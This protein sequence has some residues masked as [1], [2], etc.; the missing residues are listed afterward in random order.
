MITVT[1]L[2]VVEGQMENPSRFQKANRMESKHRPG[3]RGDVYHEAASLPRAT[4]TDTAV[5]RSVA[6]L[7]QS[8]G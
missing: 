8:D 4:R 6:A 3:R 7:V 1:A 5:T 2:E